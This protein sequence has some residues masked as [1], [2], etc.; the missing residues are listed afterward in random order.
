MS[1]PANAGNN[2]RKRGPAAAAAATSSPSAQTTEAMQVDDTLQNESRDASAEE[3][4]TTAPESNPPSQS[5]GHRK[6]DSTGSA[7]LQHPNKRQRSSNNPSAQDPSLSAGDPGEPSDTT[8]AS[9]DIADRVT[10]T[11][12]HRKSGSLR[13][14]A[15]A[16]A[17][18]AATA[19]GYGEN[20]R[21]GKMAP[22]PIGKLTQPVG[23]TT[24]PPP[25]GRPIRVYADGV[26]DLFHLGYV[27]DPSPF[28][29]IKQ[30]DFDPRR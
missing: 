2:K 12:S 15:A 9:V 28:Q 21:E 26:F 1:S 17:A 4:D 27:F 10:S 30:V 20:E 23:Y 13:G 8:E 7:S 25:A 18:S 3:G 22:P 14:K 29:T 24:N 16:A 5:A 19:D 6:A 11:S